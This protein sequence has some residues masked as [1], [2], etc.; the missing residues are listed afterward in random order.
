V[1]NRPL[2][3]LRIGNPFL[4]RTP[5]PP[6]SAVDGRVVVGLRRMGKRIIFALEGDLFV[7]L[8]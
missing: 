6:V 3:R 2:E 8:H 7:V 5:E 4:V 1:L